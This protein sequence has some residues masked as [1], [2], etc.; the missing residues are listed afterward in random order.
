MSLDVFNTDKHGYVTIEVPE[1]PPAITLDMDTDS[2]NDGVQD[3]V[4]GNGA[5]KTV[6]VQGGVGRYDVDRTGP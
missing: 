5:A 1:S 3:T 2:A 4:V 6:T